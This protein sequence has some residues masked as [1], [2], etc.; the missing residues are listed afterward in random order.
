MIFPGF[1]YHR[2]QDLLDIVVEHLLSDEGF[3]VFPLH[4]TAMVIGHCHMHKLE[5]IISWV[6]ASIRVYVQCLAEYSGLLHRPSPI[7][8]NVSS[9][10]SMCR[11]QHGFPRLHLPPGTRPAGYC[12][13]QT[14]LS[15]TD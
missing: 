2:V 15:H 7:S 14:C 1:I 3:A 6:L 13:T 12:S 9:V 5:I 10:A 11:T 8:F 4:C